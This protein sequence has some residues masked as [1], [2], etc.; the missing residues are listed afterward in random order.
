M[1]KPISFVR[2]FRVPK[3]KDIDEALGNDASFSNEFKM[4]F[5][6][7]PH[8]TSDLDWL[9]N[10]REKGQTYTQF[11]RQC[12][13]FDDN[14][15]LQ[16]Y[17]YL[18]L[19]DNDDRL[20]LL[21]IDRLIDYTKRFFQMEIKLLP[22]FTNINWNNTKHT[23]MCTM[24]GRNDSTKEITL[25]TRY[26]STSGHSQICVD[27]VLNLLKRSLPSDARCLVAITLHD[28]YSAE[29]D[30]FIAGLCHGNSSVGAFSFFRY[31][32]RL[33]FSEEFWY[34]WKIKKTKSKLMSTIILMRSCRLLT[35]E[36]GHLLGI[37]H[38]IYY[39]CLMNGSGHLEEDFAQPLFLCPIDLRKLSQL[40]GFD[41]I[42]RYEQLLDFCTENRFIDEINILKKR[43][44]I[45]KNEKRTVQTKK[46]KDFDHETTQK[47]KRLKKK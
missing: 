38:C 44:D 8:P 34:D 43:L 3:Q 30:L 41:I 40:A 33:K 12:P 37:D 20:L 47:S 4:S 23:W 24:K 29:S 27:N 32:P 16:K 42:E 17:I 39:E 26:D 45:L 1:L 25:R 46:N 36:I 11:L 28:L 13:F 19:L 9:A 7:L 31:D 22:L 21:N 5:N 10:Y 6:S 2:G 35:H 14:H 15:S 18:T